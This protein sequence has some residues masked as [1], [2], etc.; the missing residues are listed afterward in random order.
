MSRVPTHPAAGAALALALLAAVLAAAALGAFLW[1]AD[2]DPNGD[3]T[4]SSAAAGSA[5]VLTAGAAGGVLAALVARSWNL[6][7]G[8]LLVAAALG[9]LCWAPA[10]L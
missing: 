9:A 10:L 5:L 8:V 7:S 3:R 4:V 2:L 6:L 1:A